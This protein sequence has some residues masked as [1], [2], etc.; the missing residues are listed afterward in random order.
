MVG[1][2]AFAANQKHQYHVSQIGEHDVVPNHKKNKDYY[3]NLGLPSLMDEHLF[4]G[5][6]GK[7]S[8][9]CQTKASVS[10]IPKRKT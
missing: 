4:Y 9:S 5:K 1:K 2:K 6:C 3:E 8:F 7:K 10:C